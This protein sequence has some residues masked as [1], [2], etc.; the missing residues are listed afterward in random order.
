MGVCA[1]NIAE[2]YSGIPQSQ[3]AL[4]DEFFAD[5]HYWDITPEAA[6]LAGQYRY[7]AARQGRALATTDTLIAAV[8]YLHGATVVTRNVKDYPIEGLRV[9]SWSDNDSA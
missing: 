8:A 6:R 9:L 3:Y 4:W 7:Q 5:L 1:V 2:F